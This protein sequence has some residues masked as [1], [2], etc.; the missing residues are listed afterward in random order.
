MPVA[1]AICWVASLKSNSTAIIKRQVAIF[2]DEHCCLLTLLA[3]FFQ[4][5]TSI[6]LN[7]A[8]LALLQ[9]LVDRTCAH[10]F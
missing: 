4:F 6:L 8:S 10:G 1:L 7:L 9:I 5:P 2:T 3:L